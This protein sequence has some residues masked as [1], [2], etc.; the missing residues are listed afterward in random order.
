MKYVS[1]EERDRLYYYTNSKIIDTAKKIITL[2]MEKFREFNID[3]TQLEKKD[4]NESRMEMMNL[5]DKDNF[6][7]E[8]DG[9]STGNYF[10]VFNQEQTKFRDEW[11]E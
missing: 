2:V 5:F 1:Q 7:E 8:N 11:L 3:G 4:L 6:E 9:E 10:D